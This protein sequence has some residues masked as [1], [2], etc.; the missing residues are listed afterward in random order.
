MEFQGLHQWKNI[1]YVTL[2][3]NLCIFFEPDKHMGK[4]T[5]LGNVGRKHTSYSAAQVINLRI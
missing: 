2:K 5:K 4:Q 3:K 1:I